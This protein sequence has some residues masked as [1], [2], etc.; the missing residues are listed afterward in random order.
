[1][2]MAST[3]LI[4]FQ[5]TKVIVSEFYSNLLVQ[6]KDTLKDKH[7]GNITKCVSFLH[8]NAPPHWVLATQKNLAYLSY[9]Y[10]DHPPCVQDPAPSG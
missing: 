8:E 1:M 7:R 4:I 5:R 9:E 3:S 6:L 2:K 10:L